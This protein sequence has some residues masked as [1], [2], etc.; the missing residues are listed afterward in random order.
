MKKLNIFLGAVLLLL[1]FAMYSFTK[2]AK[3]Q[4]R[5]NIL[6]CIADDQSFPHA[7]AY[8]CKWI[9]TPNF[10]RVASQGIL[11]TRAYTPNAKCAPSRACII[12][13]RNSWQLDAAANHVPYF[14]EKF[15]TYSEALI[16]NGYHV[17]YVAKGWAPG[18]PGMKDGK[19]RELTGPAYN[20]FTMTPPTNQISK[21]D[22]A[23]NFEDFLNANPEGKPFCFWYG[24]TEPH[25]AYEFKSGVKKGGKNTTEIDHI[26]EFWPDNDTVRNDLLDY[27]FEIEYFDRHLGE[28]L[29]MLEEKGLLENTLIV[30]TA[31]NGMPFPRIKGQEYEL[32]NHLP[33]AMMWPKGIKNPGRVIDDFVSF[34]DYAPTFLDIAGVSP[35]KSGMQP[36]E[37]NSLL[38]LLLDQPGAKGRDFMVIGKER[39]DMGRINDEGYPI[40]GILKDGFLYLKNYHIDRWPAGNPETGYMDCDGSPTKSFILN[41]RRPKG[42][43]WYWNFSFGKRQAEELYQIS[44]D[45]EC[46]N[47][48]ADKQEYSVIKTKLAKQMTDELIREKDPRIMG[49]GDI[50]DTY[51]YSED[52]VRNFYN[53]F[54][55]GEPVKA[56]WINQSDI[57]KEKIE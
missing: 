37:G 1:S 12:T 28:M 2:K 44:S 56:G 43:S 16:E 11:F 9:K 49:N 41:D 6:F 4:S 7:G 31:D 24:S 14:P 32:S 40:R 13:G 21:N 39:H 17:G 23:K 18:N 55:S 47:N 51:P 19:K 30:V 26:F 29:K 3:E 25:R 48:L 8:G 15:K 42:Q 52:A 22:Y 50:F 45:P 33:L 20:K 54:M 10:D 34:T 46:L 38:P 35:K 53:R 36:M 27:A 57:E 5:P